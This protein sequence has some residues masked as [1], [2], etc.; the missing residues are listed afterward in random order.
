AWWV[1]QPLRSDIQLLSSRDADLLRH[2]ARLTWRYFEEFVGPQENWLPPDNIQEHPVGRVAHR[3]SPTNMGL[4]L[5]SNLAAH[6][7]G[8]LSGGQLLDR[9]AHTLGS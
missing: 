2:T 1:S 7:M 3:T 4:A 6:D 8:Y 5:L 9:T